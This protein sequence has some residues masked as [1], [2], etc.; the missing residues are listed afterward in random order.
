MISSAPIADPAAYKDQAHSLVD[1]LAPDQ[2]AAVVTLLQV[3]TN[4]QTGVPFEDEPISE[5][6]ERSVAASKAWF[7]TR[8]GRGIPH[9]EVLAEYGLRPEDFPL[10][11]EPDTNGPAR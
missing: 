10:R 6:E 4:E 11:S 3:M 1:R 2:L 7:E 8:H 5:E 9:E